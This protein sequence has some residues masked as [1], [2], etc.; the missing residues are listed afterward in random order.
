MFNTAAQAPVNINCTKPLIATPSKTP[1]TTFR[2]ELA[3]LPACAKNAAA[4]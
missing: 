1:I 2:E 4:R 3:Q